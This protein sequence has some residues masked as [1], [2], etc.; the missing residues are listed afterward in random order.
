MSGT[1]KEEERP[2]LERFDGTRPSEY[3]K[4]RRK[5]E[6]ML[7]ALPTTFTK[8]RWGAKVLEYL[9]GEAEEVCENI[10]LEKIVKEDGHK[11]VFEALDGKY[12]ELQKDALHKHLTEYFFG[13]GIRANESYRNLTVRLETAYRRLQE[14]CGAS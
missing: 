14:H 8:D 3:R 7:L 4:W 6:L 12:K 13:T 9:A 11:L 1:S 2:R 10:P 5:A